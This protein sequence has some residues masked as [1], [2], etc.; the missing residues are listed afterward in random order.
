MDDDRFY[1]DV[2]LLAEASRLNGVFAAR[3][4]E[5]GTDEQIDALVIEARAMVEE[6]ASEA[7]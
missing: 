3:V 4:E 5:A 2:A 1:G 6:A 7:L